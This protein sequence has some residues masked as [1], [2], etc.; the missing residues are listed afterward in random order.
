MAVRRFPPPWSV[1]E[2]EACFVVKDGAGQ[3]LTYVYF[4]EEP[5]GRYRFFCV[6]PV[7]LSMVDHTVVIT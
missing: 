4:E 3:K 5:E 6:T 7:T 1:D 2:L